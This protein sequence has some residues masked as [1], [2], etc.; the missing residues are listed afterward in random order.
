VSAPAPELRATWKRWIASRY[1]DPAG[2]EVLREQIA[3]GRTASDQLLGFLDE[4]RAR[5]LAGALARAPLWTP[6]W[7]LRDGDAIRRVDETSFERADPAL[8]FSRH[9]QL[10]LGA[11]LKAGAPL[12]REDQHILREF[13]VFALVSPSLRSWVEA[14]LRCPLA[15]WNSHELVRYPPGGFLGEHQDL[16]DGRLVGVN[17][18]LGD[19]A[20]GDGGVLCVAQTGEAPVRQPPRFNSLSLVHV[21]P[22]R[23]HWVERWTARATG[24]ETFAIAFRPEFSPAGEGG[25]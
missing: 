20:P 11:L 24:R 19:W 15:D 21:A 5:R 2:I 6:V 3:S 17:F 23:S 13:L 18:Y 22:G 8:R 7:A 25:R 4:E 10:T 14:I 1:C 16:L 9:E 12:S